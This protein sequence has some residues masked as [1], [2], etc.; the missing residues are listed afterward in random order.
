MRAS[1]P[2]LK[3]STLTAASISFAAALREGR[4]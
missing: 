1:R 2:L 3:T 4:Q